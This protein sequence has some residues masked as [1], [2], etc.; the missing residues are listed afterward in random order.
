MDNERLRRDV[1]RGMAEDL[2]VGDSLDPFFDEDVVAPPRGSRIFRFP[3]SVEDRHAGMPHVEGCACDECR[4]VLTADLLFE[5]S[6]TSSDE[7][8]SDSD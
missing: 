6:A 1:A 4:Y 7:T 2:A 3:L 8:G 5:D